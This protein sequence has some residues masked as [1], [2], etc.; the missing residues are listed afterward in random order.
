MKENKFNVSQPVSFV[1][2]TNG[3]F[4][5]FESWDEIVRLGGLR[6]ILPA[7]DIDNIF[8][9]KACKETIGKLQTE[10]FL[11]FKNVDIDSTLE[12]LKPFEKAI[13]LFN[14]RR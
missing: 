8:N 12:Y 7:N 4:Y 14:N 10:I 2:I 9:E 13:A 1:N 11:G 5:D 6:K 3:V